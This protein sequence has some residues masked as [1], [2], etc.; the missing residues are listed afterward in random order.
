[1]VSVATPVCPNRS[2]RR[3][4]IFLENEVPVDRR[5][6]ILGVVYPKGY[7]KIRFSWRLGQRQPAEGPQLLDVDTLALTS[8]RFVQF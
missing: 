5:T 1:M 2:N 8:Y 3:S 6:V 7:L 4:F